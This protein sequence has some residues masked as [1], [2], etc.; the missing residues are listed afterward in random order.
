MKHVQHHKFLMKHVQ[1]LKF[2]M[3]HVQHDK[4]TCATWQWNMC[5]ISNSQWNIC[6]ITMKHIEH[7]GSS[8]DSHS[9]LPKFQVLG[10]F[11]TLCVQCCNMDVL[12]VHFS[13]LVEQFETPNDFI[14]K[15]DEYQSC[16]THEDLQL[17]VWSSCHL[18]KFYQ[19]KFWNL[20][21]DKF[22]PEFEHPN[23]FSWKSDEY[24]SWITHE[25]IKLLY[26]SFLHPTKR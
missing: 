21:N 3:K 10:R 17:L 13:M 20:K 7:L 22:K 26:W 12:L 11:E 18:T 15:S 6:N 5:N 23:D 24:Q 8:L 16:I 14:S 4:E 9:I 25:D 1:H 2:S 19:I